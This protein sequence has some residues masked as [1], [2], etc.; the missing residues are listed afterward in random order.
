[1]ATLDQKHLQSQIEKNIAE[2]EKNK[3]EKLRAEF[4]TKSMQYTFWLKPI[5]GGLALGIAFIPIYYTAILPSQEA[6]IIQKELTNKRLEQKL[7]H[8]E[9]SLDSS[10]AAFEEERSL[11]SNQL[12]TIEGTMKKK[13]SILSIY[14]VELTR[15]KSTNPTMRDSLNSF[16]VKKKNRIL[17]VDDQPANN[18]PIANYM[19]RQGAVIVKALSTN[20]AIDFIKTQGFDYIISDMSRL[21]NDIQNSKAGLDLLAYLKKA[22]VKTPLAFYSGSGTSQRDIVKAVERQKVLLTN[23]SKELFDFLGF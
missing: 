6:Q 4:E 3:A 16:L 12:E 23:D 17:W 13:D 9:M 22:R 20:E 11:V 1:M 19:Q 18:D 5:I 15:L 8:L 21:E 14:L 2:A 10:M 7:F